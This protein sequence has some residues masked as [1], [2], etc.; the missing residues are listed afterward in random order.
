MPLSKKMVGLTLGLLAGGAA[1]WPTL[2][3]ADTQAQSPSATP[4]VA[5]QSAQSQPPNDLWIKFSKPKTLIAANIQTA[6]SDVQLAAVTLQ[7]AY[8]QQQLSTRIYLSQTAQDQTWLQQ[9]VPKDVKV[10]DLSVSQSDPNAVLETLLAQFGHSIKGAIVTDPSNPDTVNLAT[11]LAGIDDA[12]VIT[13]SQEAL[14]QS[15]G[16]KILHDFRND[17]LT[18]TVATYQWAIE[19]LLPKTTTKDLVMLNP[20]ATGDIRDYAVATKSFVFYLTSTNPQQKTLM[21]EI[22]QHTP[23]NTPILGYIPDEGPDVAELS[24]Q[25]HFLNASDFLANESV[26]ASMPSPK[27]FHQSQPHAVKATPKTVYVAF[28]TSEGDNAQYVQHR[29]LQLWQDPDLGAVPTGW[30]IAPGMIDFAPTLMSYYYQHLPKSSEL[31]PGPSGVGYATAETGSNLVQFAKLSGEFLRQDDM[32]TVDYWG[33][34]SALDTY[35]QA[36]GVPSISYNGPI[37]YETSGN[38]AIFGQTS[39]YIAA[40]NDLL[41]TIEQQATNEQNGQPL[42]L[43]PLI[44]AWTLTPSDELQ[45]AQQLTLFGEKT[46]Q[47]FVFTTPSELALTM[48]AYHNQQE[49]NLPTYNAQAIPGS[50]L[51]KDGVQ[52]TQLTGFTPTSPQGPNLIS[53]PSGEAGTTGWQMAYSGQ[54]ATLTNTTYQGESALEWQVQAD[55]GHT[56]WLS[57]YPS[58]QNGKTYTFSVQLAGSGV[59][60]MNLWTGT[61]NVLTLP[62]NLSSKFQTLTWTVTIPSNAPSGQTGQAPQLQ[63]GEPDAGDV[64]VYIRNASVRESSPSN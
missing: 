59:A 29:M 63:V 8:N 14:V 33:T 15:Y 7:G 34:P 30:T 44:D 3:F 12:M 51:I 5:T 46:G 57:Y 28:I 25:G 55:I 48:K 35:A 2:V 16:I 6:S 38:T 36:S 45:I 27:S 13:P 18:G 21:D 43:E 56:D 49:E 40:P 53:N 23:A 47:R 61:S 24:S 11:T 58:V 1:V 64:N 52:P 50:A 60:Y 37:G 4:S 22:L 19:N 32:H 20:G 41:S 39:S 10:T 62:V 9:A 17:H 31:L 42:F 54:D 26:W